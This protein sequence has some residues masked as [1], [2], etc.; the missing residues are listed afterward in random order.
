M[1]RQSDSHK[2]SLRER[3]GCARAA[4]GRMCDRSGERLFSNASSS[5]RRAP[6]LGLALAGILA[7]AA[8]LWPMSFA[9]AQEHV[10][11]VRQPLVGGAV[12][13]AEKQEQ[14]GLLGYA[15]GSGLCSASLLRNDWV[16]T[17]AHCVEVVIG[18]PA[19]KPAASMT[20]TASWKDPQS[21]VGV[22]V[23]SFRPNDVALIKVAAPF[24]VNGSTVGYS[25]LIFADGQ[26]PYFGEPAGASL[27]VFGQGI[28]VFASGA[29]ASAVPSSNDGE[30]TCRALRPIIR[31][32]ISA[33]RGVTT[34]R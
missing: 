34:A 6:L 24:K 31:R 30:M 16:I 13:S 12:V 7:L 9:S 19:L 26:F 8:A 29:G 20:L 1:Q 10:G 23:V 15:D 32:A 17:A 21:Q 25:R 28:N 22:R 2:E 4:R 33:L 27:L 5:A 11:T 14:F 3:Y 18:Q